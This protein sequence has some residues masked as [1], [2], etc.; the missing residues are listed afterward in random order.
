LNKHLLFFY[1]L[2]AVSVIGLTFFVQNHPISGFDIHITR[3]IQEK[4]AWDITLLM[5]FISF[6]GNPV[7]MPL[8]VIFASLFFY[9]TYYRREARYTFAVIL[10]DLCNVLFKIL[11]HRP[12]PTLENAKILLKFPQFGFPSSHVVHYVVFFGFILTVMIVNKKIPLHWRIIIGI[13]CTLLIFSISISRIYLGAHWA[14]DVMGGYLFGVVYLGII[15]KFYF[16]DRGLK[17]S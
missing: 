7:G 13:F 11:V 1:A 10:P 15:L 16:K 5:K 3:E 4:S 2:V 12:R 6:F 14:T 9:L 17:R 8:S